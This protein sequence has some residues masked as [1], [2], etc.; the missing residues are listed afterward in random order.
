M[1]LIEINDCERWDAWQRAQVLSQFTQSWAWGE[2]RGEG[3]APVRRFVLQDETGE[4]LA[5]AQMSY[6]AKKLNTGF[7]RA[8]RGPVFA[9]T[10]ST[11]KKKET[12][13]EFC[14]QL[15]TQK[16]L[17]DR[18]LF[19]RFEPSVE[20]EESQGMMTTSFRR[21]SH[22]DPSSTLVLNVSQTQDE[23]L[24]GMHEKTRYN[25]R[26]AGRKGVTTRIADKPSDLETFLDLAIE[27]AARDGFTQYGREHL[28]RTYQVMHSNGLAQI[29]L[30][31]HEGKIL[32]ADMEMLFGD[33]VTYLHGASSSASRN[34]MAPYLVHWDAIVD[35][36]RRGFK[37]YDFWGINPQS[38]AMYYYRDA[39]EGITRF[40]LGFGGR[41]MNYI[42]T[43]DLPLNYF[44]Y[45][46]VYIK[47]ILRG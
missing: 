14:R 31:E 3:G 43:W 47:E 30:A 19:W 24:A 42:G 29:R 20:L 8:E 39:W 33:T 9:S 6:R 22:G 46:L 1:N 26:L 38:K 27:T 36:Q 16:G 25:I 5:A 4:W 45:R 32:V 28:K 37:Y 18:S 12:F 40:K 17:R 21:A 23:I 13:W 35:A 34:L 44:L 10:L 2:L 15:N 41:R 11:E 7:W